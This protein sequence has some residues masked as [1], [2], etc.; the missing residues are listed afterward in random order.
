MINCIHSSSTG[1]ENCSF[2]WIAK[3]PKE[4]N[5]MKTTLKIHKICTLFLSIVF[6]VGAISLPASAATKLSVSEQ[7]QIEAVWDRHEY[8]L[9]ENFWANDSNS[10]IAAVKAAQKLLTAAGY[11]VNVDGIFGP[12]TRK[13]TEQYQKDQ[14]LTVDGKIGEKTFTR[15]MQVVKSNDSSVKDIRI[16][17]QNTISIVSGKSSTVTLKFSGV[18]IDRASV[19][20]SGN[21]LKGTVKNM[22]WKPYPQECTATIILTTTKS[23]QSGHLQ[24]NLFNNSVGNIGSKRI[25]VIATNT[26]SYGNKMEKVI[27][28]INQNIGKSGAA[29]GYHQDYC[30]FI[31]SDTMKRNGIPVASSPTPCD[32]VVSALNSQLGT[33]YSFRENNVKSLKENGLRST[34]AVATSSRSNFTPKRGDI[35]CFLWKDDVGIYNWSHAGIVLDYDSKSKQIKTLEGNTSGGIVAQK[36][37]SFDSQVVGILRINQ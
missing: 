28:E 32:L 5:I 21:G 25:S 30:S 17:T 9:A 24:L 13:A 16:N 3:N 1:D 10:G 4:E 12:M 33:Y 18:G 19:D 20:I 35:L 37:R 14:K 7:K 6:L 36:T 11:P 31:L 34:K 15:L 22:Q 27:Q 26:S 29:I 8:V 23:F 2:Y